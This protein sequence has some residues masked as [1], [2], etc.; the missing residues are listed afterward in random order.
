MA[1]TIGRLLAD[2][3]F[4]TAD[5]ITRT[6]RGDLSVRDPRRL[7][8]VA[9]IFI[10]AQVD[11]N[12]CSLPPLE[13]KAESSD[14]PN[15]YWITHNSRRASKIVTKYPF[16]RGNSYT[17]KGS[18]RCDKRKTHATQPVHKQGRNTASRG[19]TQSV[20]DDLRPETSDYITVEVAVSE[21]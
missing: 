11:T 12:H 9:K 15:R 1:T 10:L 16:L 5:W 20:V 6:E 4:N 7:Q 8:F 17:P 14:T 19:S 2:M 13:T 3:D 21:L 18:K